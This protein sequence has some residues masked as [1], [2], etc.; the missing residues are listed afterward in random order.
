MS[1]GDRRL[2]RGA[3]PADPGER[4]VVG[5]IHARHSWGS[6]EQPAGQEDCDG[7]WGSLELADTSGGCS[8]EAL[9]RGMMRGVDQVVRIS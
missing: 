8:H 6:G 5:D 4:S 3:I 1:E 9:Q 7:G 2:R